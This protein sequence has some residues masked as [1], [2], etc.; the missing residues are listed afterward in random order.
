MIDVSFQKCHEVSKRY[1]NQT[2]I[3]GLSELAD[4]NN[5]VNSS[6]SGKNRKNIM[7]L[8]D[9]LQQTNYIFCR[10][11]EGTYTT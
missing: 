8:H 3:Q 5:T 9:G 1:V 7:K 11:K 4:Q 6:S 10:G 2:K